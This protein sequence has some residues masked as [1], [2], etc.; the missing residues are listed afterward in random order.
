MEQLKSRETSGVTH[1][2]RHGMT[3]MIREMGEYYDVSPEE[4]AETQA[5]LDGFKDD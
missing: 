2:P 5:M 3:T 4:M 1:D